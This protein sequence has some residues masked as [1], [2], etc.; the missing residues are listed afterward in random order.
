M[1]NSRG[2]DNANKRKLRRKKH[3][4]IVEQGRAAKAAAA[5]K[6]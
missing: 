6:A 1:G 2:R 5:L 3:D 4:R